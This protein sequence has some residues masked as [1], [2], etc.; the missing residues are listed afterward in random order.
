MDN[1]ELRKKYNPDGSL[2]R[3]HQL[4]MLEMLLE[5]DRICK[6]YKIQY[7]LSSGTLLGAIRHNGFIPWD[8]DLDI[9]MLRED[10]IRLI[11][12]LPYELSSKYT[13]QDENSDKFY[14][15]HYAK[16]RDKFSIL[17][18]QNGYDRKLR[19]KGIYIDIFYIEKHPV[20][21]HNLSLKTTGHMYKIWRCSKNDESSIKRVRII[22]DTN[23][24]IIYPLF[25]LFCRL[26]KVK[27]Y[28]WG[29]GIPFYSKRDIQDLFPLTDHNFEN[30]SFPVPHNSDG[31]LHRMYGDYMKLPDLSNLGGHVKQLIFLDN[32]NR[33][34]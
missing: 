20:W 12:V 23:K 21:L 33:Y 32:S 5:I 30:Y 25:R 17:N 24:K 15:Y 14:F 11:K 34:E 7:W 22:Y 18:E 9:E 29:M 8:D 26:F 13:L 1:E 28:V 16:I 19:H 3:S 4:R 27:T 2:L 6:K 31:Y 10:Y